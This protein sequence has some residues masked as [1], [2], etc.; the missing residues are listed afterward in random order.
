MLEEV[1][2][3]QELLVIADR[4]LY[5]AK[6]ATDETWFSPRSVVRTTS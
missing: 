2:V 1:S 4:R 6:R 3:K 5:A